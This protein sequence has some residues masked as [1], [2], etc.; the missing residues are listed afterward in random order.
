[1]WNPRPA[2]GYLITAAISAVHIPGTNMEVKAVFLSQGATNMG[3][4]LQG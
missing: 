3:K 2:S 1:M 4:E